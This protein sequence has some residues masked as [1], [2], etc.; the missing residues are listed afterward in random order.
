MEGTLVPAAAKPMGPAKLS[1]PSIAGVP[2]KQATVLQY[3]GLQGGL[4]EA[5]RGVDV[6]FG[7]LSKAQFDAL[8]KEFGGQ[9]QVRHEPARE[10]GVVDFLPPAIQGLVGKDLDAGGMVELAGTEELAEYLRA[11]T[12]NV[13][14]GA[15]PNCHGTAWEMVRAFQGQASAHVQLGYGD[16]LLVGGAYEEHFKSLGVTAPGKQADLS[17]LKAG[18]VVTVSTWDRADK[19]ERALLHSAVYVGGGLFFEKPDTESDTSET[20]YRLVTLEQL[21]ASVQATVGREPLS[22]HARRPSAPLAPL[23]QQF[24]S[25]DAPALEAALAKQGKTVGKPLVMEYV[26]GTGGGIQGGAL[27]VVL[28]K[29]VSVGAD[30]RG[31]LR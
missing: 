4:A 2:V 9:T 26:M 11:E 16:A 23:A 22:L 6:T 31:V 24:A 17:K 15:T 30:G 1:Q 8:V 21:T 13:R 10:Y 7:K 3:T 14:V 27:S 18:D 5:Q 12:R 20:P 19:A 25:P 28:P 29:Q